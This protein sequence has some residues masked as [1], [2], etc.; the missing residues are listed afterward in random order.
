MDTNRDSWARPFY[1]SYAWIKCRRD[2]ARSVNGLCER[3][4]ARGLYVPGDEVHHKIRLNPSNVNDPSVALN[5]DNLELLCKD[6]H[7]AEHEVNK[8]RWRIGEEGELTI[9]GS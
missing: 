9:V 3:C 1:V 8:R 4:L 2:Y 5:W 6:C 7:M